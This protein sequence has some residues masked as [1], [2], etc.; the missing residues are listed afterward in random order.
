MKTGLWAIKLIMIVSCFPY[1]PTIDD[2]VP[3]P[4]AVLFGGVHGERCSFPQNVC[5]QR[6][7]LWRG[8][9]QQQKGHGT[10][11][12]GRVCVHNSHF[13]IGNVYVYRRFNANADAVSYFSYGEDSCQM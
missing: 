7:E 6:S 5:L 8:Q 4:P 12:K 3:N 13:P 11:T 1:F 9:G 2:E 10:S